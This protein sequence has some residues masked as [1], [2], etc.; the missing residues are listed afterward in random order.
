MG[1]WCPA[2]RRQAVGQKMDVLEEV[3]PC[4][5][6]LLV[7]LR[8]PF[9]LDDPA[10]VQPRADHL[11][12]PDV[13]AAQ[14]RA[15]LLQGV[16]RGVV[17]AVVATA[18]DYLRTMAP[19]DV[20]VPGDDQLLADPFDLDFANATA[21]AQGLDRQQLSF[22]RRLGDIACGRHFL[23]IELADDLAALVDQVD[24]GHEHRLVDDRPARA[25]LL[26]HRFNGPQ[27]IVG[28]LA[29]RQAAA[30]D[31]RREYVTNVVQVDDGIADSLMRRLADG[32]RGHGIFSKGG[33]MVAG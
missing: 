7:A 17:Y 16:Q 26:N 19:R 23:A 22:A 13:D 30:R 12:E 32:V 20:I 5:V 9:L 33:T 15:N 14:Q 11:V 31:R 4:A 27:G 18:G 24:A 8:G 25:L 6:Q 10:Q 2:A 3:G 1:T 21:D 28:L 29:E